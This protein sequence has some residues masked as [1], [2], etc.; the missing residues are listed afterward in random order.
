MTIIL[1]GEFVAE[2]MRGISSQEY[3]S[4]PA[5]STA[6][7]GMALVFFLRWLYFEGA[8]ERHVHTPEQVRRFH[9]WSYA[10]LPLFLGP[11]VAGVGL[12]RLIAFQEGE[13]LH[14]AEAVIFAGSVAVTMVSLAAIGG[15]SRR[16][17]PVPR[18]SLTGHPAPHSAGQ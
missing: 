2:V 17:S 6:F 12:K 9:V 3:W 4:L 7:G 15:V 10:H 1:L 16:A 5:A 14:N 18:A 13:H 11:G 8:G